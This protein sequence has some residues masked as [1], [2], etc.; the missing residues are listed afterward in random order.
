M[1]AVFPFHITQG[2]H[3]KAIYFYKGDALKSLVCFSYNESFI[4]GKGEVSKSQSMERDAVLTWREAA[5]LRI[6]KFPTFNAKQAF[7][8]LPLRLPW[9]YLLQHLSFTEHFGREYMLSHFTLAQI[10]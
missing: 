10:F 7:S 5:L 3:L 4:G 2:V 6:S 9:N 1:E 8:L